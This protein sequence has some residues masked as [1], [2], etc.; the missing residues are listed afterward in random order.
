M[1]DKK[2]N[3][4][5]E[6]DTRRP[7]KIEK[8]PPDLHREYLDMD[9]DEEEFGHQETPESE[10]E[11][12]AEPEKPI[13]TLE[14]LNTL[15]QY[16]MDFTVL[17][18]LDDSDW[19]EECCEVIREYFRDP[20]KI[21][22]TVF[23]DHNSLKSM[24][25]FPTYPVD[26]L[27]YFLRSPWQ[28]Y[29]AENFLSTIIFGSINHNVENAVLKFME[30]I[31]SPMVFS[32]KE[33][34]QTMRDAICTNLNMFLISLNDATY[35]AMGL[36]ILYIPREGLKFEKLKSPAYE[37]YILLENDAE[38]EP[39]KSESEE[40]ELIGRLEKV[41][42]YWIRQI[43]EALAKDTAPY[44]INSIIDEFAFWNDRHGNL[45]CLH[46][47][48]INE[49]VLFIVKKLENV[50]SA[51]VRQFASLTEKVQ[52]GIKE[53]ASN[54][55]YL[56]T[57]TELCEKLKAPESV[58][59]FITEILFLIQ[60]I[61]TDSPFYNT[62]NKI[63]I[64]CRAL[65]TQI[66]NQCQDYIEL[67][68]IFEGDTEKGRSMLKKCISCC[69]DYK[70]IYDRLTN[71]TSD[72]ESR[73]K[74]NVD[75]EK[76]FNHV[77]TFTQRCHDVIEICDAVTVFGRSYRENK[78]GGSK[79]LEHKKH[80]A[81]IES[82]FYENLDMIKNS[83]DDILDVAKPV[84]LD[85]ISEFRHHMMELE[86]MARN[87][88]D[89]MFA[90]VQNVEEGIEALYALR[91]FEERQ[92]LRET[93]HNKWVG[94]W[95]IFNK[96][97][98]N[99]VTTI[100]DELD[101]HH[102][103]VPYYSGHATALRIKRNY[104]SRQHEIMINS[105][106]WFGDC[107]AQLE[108]LQKYK[109]LII[110]IINKEKALF[111]SWNDK[112]DDITNFKMKL[113]VPVLQQQ[114]DKTELIQVNMDQNL[115][116]II[117]EIKGWNKL[118]YDVKQY[119][120][121]LPPKMDSLRNK[122]QGAVSLCI[123][124]NGVL[125]TLSNKEQ[126]LFKELLKSLRN[127]I[128]QGFDKITWDSDSLEK[129]YNECTAQI[130]Q[131][132]EVIQTYKEINLKIHQLFVN[133]SMVN[134]ISNDPTI[135]TYTLDDLINY[136]NEERNRGIT[137][138]LEYHSSIVKMIRKLEKMFDA[139]AE[140]IILQPEVQ[141]INQAIIQICNSII[142]VV[143]S[144]SQFSKIMQLNLK[145]IEIK[146]C[147]NDNEKYRNLIKE[148]NTEMEAVQGWIEEYLASIDLIKEV[149]IIF[150][151]ISTQT[152]T[153]ATID[154]NI[155][156]AHIIQCTNLIIKI[157]A[158]EDEVQAHFISIDLRVLKSTMIEICDKW[159]ESL[160]VRLSKMIAADQISE[161]I[162]TSAEELSICSTSVENG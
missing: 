15:V 148:I 29:N 37:E 117:E 68:T 50:R 97:L 157:H 129:F 71:I 146:Q 158:V 100:I 63:E 152:I 90:D 155:I 26:G 2:D 34:P 48:L 72:I 27:T 108:I 65:S 101:M 132:K 150:D 59:P 35:K 4:N 67:D 60:F 120:K 70:E 25:E 6:S 18:A 151:Q 61:W 139:N 128:S 10:E 76:V 47:Q 88:I 92:Y 135:E 153:D 162:T 160:C 46:S 154:R 89:D 93:L 12:P 104:L 74:W 114:K 102:P 94:V 32:S 66:I 78:F 111:Q 31:Y 118:K 20:T 3:Q 69:Q 144:V 115:L 142:S 80:Y 82:L 40:N 137:E 33:W 145:S 103:S 106:D 91:M 83:Y 23:Y 11:L 149:S 58:K 77:D 54:I 7:R 159:K 124:Y 125:K 9:T 156:E 57:L 1:A 45:S 42:R 138:I 17:Y 96:E 38:E 113:K 79:G 105:S 41:A 51:S 22:L 122:Y 143:C 43:R 44:N 21:I 84:W 86:N 98:E 85:D 161:T 141:L 133:I 136:L 147:I 131:S 5:D 64:L 110:G 19:N 73:K 140:E 62:S 24:L 99:C 81:K 112:V 127:S 28:I 8:S 116:M 126:L 53:A 109:N 13:F 30:N 56:N 75:K 49:N 52:M 123:Q 119:I 95:Q 134:L 87:L 130:L 121:A 36:T 107:D 14:E 16:V 55:I 39:E